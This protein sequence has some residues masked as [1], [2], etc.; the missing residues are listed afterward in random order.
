MTRTQLVTLVAA[1]FI[2]EH[3]ARRPL[4]SAPELLD[5]ALDAAEELVI[6]AEVK[7]QGRG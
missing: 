7:Y 1:H 4:D 2:V 6:A 5:R 3:N